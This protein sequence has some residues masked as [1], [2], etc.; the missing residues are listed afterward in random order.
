MD[1]R[2]GGGRASFWQ[3]IC[4]IYGKRNHTGERFHMIN[5]IVAGMLYLIMMFLVLF[6]FSFVT[7]GVTYAAAAFVRRCMHWRHQPHL[8]L[9]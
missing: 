8:A 3:A 1:I 2:N 4:C 6:C 7:I 5:F 9:K